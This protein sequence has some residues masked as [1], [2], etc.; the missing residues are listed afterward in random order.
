MKLLFDQNISR[1]LVKELEFVFPESSHVYL[2]GLYRASDDEI[3]KFAKGN[4]FTIVTQDTDFNERSLI[5]GHPPKIICM[6]LGN[7]STQKI[8]EVLVQRKDDIELFLK[9]ET[10][11]CLQILQ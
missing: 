6:R 11:G 1:K 10:L 5:H 9:D 7:S 8:K 4:G 2:L 3:W